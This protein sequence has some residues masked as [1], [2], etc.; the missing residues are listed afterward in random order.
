MHVLCAYV[1]ESYVVCVSVCV[2]IW[3]GGHWYYSF[4]FCM[5][6]WIENKSYFYFTDFRSFSNNLISYYFCCLVCGIYSCIYITYVYFL[7]LCIKHL[8]FLLTNL[9][10]Q[11][12][13]HILK[14]VFNALTTIT[15]LMFLRFPYLCLFKYYIDCIFFREFYWNFALLISNSF[16]FFLC[17]YA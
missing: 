7:W 15:E 2:Y 11:Q 10:K 17:M 14:V 4:S 16:E 5:K 9:M 6:N 3:F 13:S 12:F 8:Y 1:C